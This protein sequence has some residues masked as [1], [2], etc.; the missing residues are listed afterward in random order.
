MSTQN[1]S[2]KKKE[3]QREEKVGKIRIRNGKLMPSDRWQ[4]V[5]GDSIARNPKEI[6]MLDRTRIVLGFRCYFYSTMFAESKMLPAVRRLLD[7]P[8][9]PKRLSIDTAVCAYI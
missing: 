3:K 8:Y 9:I 5:I 7:L 2:A 4:S 6:V 1:A